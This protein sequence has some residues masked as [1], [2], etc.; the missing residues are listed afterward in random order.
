M[1]Q[2]IRLDTSGRNRLPGHVAAPGTDHG[3]SYR[4]DGD[5]RRFATD[6]HEVD[7]FVAPND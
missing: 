3:K 5:Y 2:N 7:P 1:V 4:C 6:T